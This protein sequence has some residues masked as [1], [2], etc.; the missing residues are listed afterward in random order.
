M[1]EEGRPGE[2]AQKSESE[3]GKEGQRE[4]V[5]A[6]LTDCARALACTLSFVIFLGQNMNTASEIFVKSKRS[7]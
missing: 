4:A 6:Y 7:L 5:R 1:R 3:E 2:Q